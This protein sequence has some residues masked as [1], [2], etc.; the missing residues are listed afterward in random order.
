[1]WSSVYESTNVVLPDTPFGGFCLTCRSQN[2]FNKTLLYSI[3][4]TKICCHCIESDGRASSLPPIMS[5]FDSYWRYCR[6]HS[7]Y[8]VG[9]TSQTFCQR[10]T[11][12]WTG[13]QIYKIDNF[14]IDTDSCYIFEIQNGKVNYKERS[15]T[16]HHFFLCKKE[17]DQKYISSTKYVK[18]TT[19]TS[20]PPFTSE[21]ALFNKSWPTRGNATSKFIAS[22]NSPSSK[23]KASTSNKG[24]FT[25]TANT[26]P[27][28]KSFTFSVTSLKTSFN[29]ATSRIITTSLAASSKEGN[30][31]TI[32][33]SSIVLISVVF[34]T[35]CLFKRRNLLCIQSKQQQAK[36]GEVFNNTTYDDLVVRNQKPDV[37]YANT[38]LENA[39]QGNI[40]KIDD[41]YVEKEK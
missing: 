5:T 32:V 26:S 20:Q 23:S 1:M 4:C 22:T 2:D 27:S 24:L 29:N 15:C 21:T 19:Y 16:E 41:I 25:Y 38:T 14:N 6:N 17:F 7:K 33:G 9:D 30:K 8:I 12:I 40:C 13:L 10:D 18:S 11:S 31:A 3:D 34:I 37:I 28:K 35:I 36:S 39:N